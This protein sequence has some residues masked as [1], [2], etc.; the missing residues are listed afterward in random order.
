MA[1]R[2][3]RCSSWTEVRRYPNDSGLGCLESSCDNKYKFIAKCE[4]R[5]CIRMACQ[6]KRRA[7]RMVKGTKSN[8]KTNEKK[9]RRTHEMNYCCNAPARAKSPEPSNWWTSL[10]LHTA[11]PD[12]PHNWNPLHHKKGKRECPTKLL[13]QQAKKHR[14]CVSKYA[15]SATI[16]DDQL[17]STQI[18]TTAAKCKIV[19]P[20]HQ[21][22]LVS[23]V[24]INAILKD[25]QREV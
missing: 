24:V 11:A 3:F 5:S 15:Q 18:T 10:T 22:T 4:E 17:T 9:N 20:Q 25:G 13:S 23:S 19:P 14:A 7:L 6:L 2:A 12:A 1:S 21:L 8:T 16:C